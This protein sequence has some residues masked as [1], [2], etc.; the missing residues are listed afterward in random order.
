M[1]LL[2][3]CVFSL[4]TAEQL[5]AQSANGILHG[6]APSW[7]NSK[8]YK[9]AADP[10]SKIGFRVYL[11][12]NNAD[13]AEALARAVSDPTS[14]SYRNFLT[15][16]QFRAQFAPTQSQV[17]VVQSWL[18][19]QGFTL[20][21]TP[22][23][24]HYVSAKGSVGQAQTAFRTQINVYNVNGKSVRAPAA[25][26]VLPASVTPYV[27]GVVGLDDSAEFIHTNRVADAN[28]PAPDGFRN[29]Q[30]LSAYWAQLSSP[31][32]FPTGY[33]DLPLGSVPWTQAGLTPAQ[34]KGAYG[35]T[36]KDTG[37]G[38]TVAVIDAYAA[39]TILQDV[40]EWSARRGLPPMTA[41]QLV[42]VV[43]PGTYNFPENPRQDPQGWY[44]EETL[45]IE[46]IHGMAPGAKIVYV[47]A[48][49]NYQDLDAAMNHV[50]DKK[51]AQIVSN[52][53][54]FSTEYL[55]PGYI[56]PFEHT[57]IQAAIEGIGVYFSSGDDGD[58]T[59]NFGYATVDYPA[60]SPWVVSVGG[61]SLGVSKA[62][63]RAVETGWGTGNYICNT[64]SLTVT[65]GS[66][67]YGAGG[68]VS[69]VFAQ[70]GYQ[71]D[72]GFTLSGRGVPDV[73]AVADPNTGM[74][75]GETQAFPD[76]TYY[77]EYKIGG[78]SLSCP[79]FAGI[80]ALA[81]QAAG[82]PHGF[83]NPAIYRNRAAFYDVLPVKTAVARRAYLN[84]VDASA[85][86]N[87]RLRTFDDYSGSP[88][89]HTNA[90]WDNVTGFGTPSAALLSALGK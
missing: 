35:L 25:D 39:P 74:A 79:L 4:L 47:G 77:D 69:K 54:G 9:A 56:K 63:T 84:F 88:T 85:G 80:M 70:P 19:S 16:A 75:V 5:L 71:A 10:G 36:N 21:Y 29:A 17:S 66:W 40:N 3:T 82:K 20:V 76:G 87:D 7:A 45:D 44:G 62:N 42:Q 67:F 89:Q 51:L 59:I 28:A 58:E 48:P 1:K 27:S 86:T 64:T 15:P 73:A 55:P 32:S 53:Y 34:I 52:S 2:L 24:N 43:A 78:T 22:D 72:A 81:D 60:C 68:G 41:S 6:S 23:N 13:A 83:A 30:P 33:R 31:Y 57:L 65:R 90:G 11:G 49:N 50:V 61:T 26:I 12:W 14:P 37:A 18:Q 38:Q 8:N 46:A